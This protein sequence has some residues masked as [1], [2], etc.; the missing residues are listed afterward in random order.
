ME[1]FCDLVK[2]FKTLTEVQRPGPGHQQ[3][4]YEKS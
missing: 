3:S 4:K 1:H 2:K